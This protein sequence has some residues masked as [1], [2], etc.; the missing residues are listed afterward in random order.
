MTSPD[1]APSDIVEPGTGRR[2]KQPRV[3]RRHRLAWII[4]ESRQ[5]ITDVESWNDNRPDCPAMDCEVER[6]VLEMATRAAR[7]WDGG[8]IPAAQA[9]M[10]EL[11]RYAEVALED[12]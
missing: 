7:L 2:D 3:R 8:E 9:V 6:V 5:F 11:S 12:E 10:T 1:T 4:H